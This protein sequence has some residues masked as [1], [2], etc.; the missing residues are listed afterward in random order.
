MLLPE[1]TDVR[2]VGVAHVW[3]YVD[4]EAG[5]IRIGV[6]EIAVRR[7]GRIDPDDRCDR[8]SGRFG[9]VHCG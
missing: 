4:V 6:E 2:V 9:I 5:Q 7:R 1:D 3:R 8:C